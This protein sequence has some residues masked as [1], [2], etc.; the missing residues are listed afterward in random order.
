MI[1]IVPTLSLTLVLRAEELLG[2]SLKL[3]TGLIAAS[4][5]VCNS[6][7]EEQLSNEPR[8]NA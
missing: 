7:F 3:E 6:K 5:L 4:M 2:L 8:A 1:H